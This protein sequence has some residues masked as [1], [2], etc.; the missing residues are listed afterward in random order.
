ML[1]FPPFAVIGTVASSGAKSLFKTLFCHLYQD[2]KRPPAQNGT[3]LGLD[4]FSD[5]LA[6]VQSD[7]TGKIC[8]NA[9]KN[10][11]TGKDIDD[12]N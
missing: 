10:K 12:H 5:Y 11:L 6:F 9:V 2:S 3:I 1:M 7:I 4:R 8:Y